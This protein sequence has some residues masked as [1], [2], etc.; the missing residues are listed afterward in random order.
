MIDSGRFLRLLQKE[1]ETYR[2]A[3]LR[4]VATKERRQ[5]PLRVLYPNPTHPLISGEPKA[6]AEASRRPP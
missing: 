1:I 4:D 3:S 5:L 2:D 6:S